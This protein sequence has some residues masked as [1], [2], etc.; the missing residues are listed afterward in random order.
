MRRLRRAHPPVASVRDVSVD[1][2]AAVSS[3][4][5]FD[6][7]EYEADDVVVLFFYQ[8]AGDG[9]L[10]TPTGWTLIDVIYAQPDADY[11]V[12]SYYRKMDG[13]EGSTITLSYSGAVSDTRTIRARI[14]SCTDVTGEV[15]GDMQISSLST[16]A[17]FPEVALPWN[18]AA[19]TI[20]IAGVFIRDPERLNGN[21]MTDDGYTSIF[22]GANL[23]GFTKSERTDSVHPLGGPA[24]F[25]DSGT[26][27]YWTTATIAVRGLK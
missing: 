10:D 9:T 22:E 5:T 16:D 4:A 8:D 19:T 3:Q 24:T 15:E 11:S 26:A 7:P 13:S 18:E 21:I 23:N 27:A 6:L 20:I 12:G 25:S 2:T 14:I 17:E 1:N